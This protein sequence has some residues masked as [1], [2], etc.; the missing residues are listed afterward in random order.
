[1][2]SRVIFSAKSGKHILDV[3]NNDRAIAGSENFGNNLEFIWILNQDPD[4]VERHA[5]NSVLTAAETF[6]SLIL[7]DL[8]LLEYGY[9]T[10]FIMPGCERFGPATGGGGIG[11]IRIAEQL[12]G[13]SSGAGYCYLEL[14]EIQPNGIKKCVKKID[15]R[16]R[17]I[18]ETN[19]FGNITILRKKKNLTWPQIL[20]PLISFL[21]QLKDDQ[22]E[23]QVIYSKPKFLDYILAIEELAKMGDEAQ[24]KLIEILQDPK[25]K[26]HYNA[27]ASALMVV[28]P[29]KTSKD[30]VKR[31]IEKETDR[32][33]IM[34]YK[35]LLDVSR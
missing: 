5:R 8:E 10:K 28:F 21:K 1:M 14:M 22:I 23:I 7:N 4:E 12:Y 25:A 19:N 11:G 20:P 13:L 26:K 35:I 15:C 6:Y 3:S 29:S 32:D 2:A 33:Q 17:K 24:N 34:V 18:I 30:A 31:L 9:K 16:N 27:I